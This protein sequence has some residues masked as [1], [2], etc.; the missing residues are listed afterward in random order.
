MKTTLQIIFIVSFFFL[1]QNSRAQIITNGDFEQWVPGAM[2]LDPV[3]W[4]TNNGSA[5]HPVI[6]QG[7]P[8]SGLYAVDFL[9]DSTGPGQ[10]VGGSLNF[11]YLGNLRPIALSGFWKGQIQTFGDELAVSMYVFDNTFN[12]IG[13]GSDYIFTTMSAWTAF[14]IPVNYSA[15][16]DAY[17]TLIAISLFSTVPGNVASMD[18]VTLTYTTGTND[19]I[20]AHFPS[21]VVR[22]AACGD[23]R[24]YI[25]LLSKSSIDIQVFNEFGQV[26]FSKQLQDVSGHNELII[27]SAGF[28]SGIYYCAV[29]GEGFR[30]SAKF[31]R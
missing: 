14:N 25:D 13:V 4:F 20:D 11:S 10:Y 15:P 8:H 12:T 6:A 1:F 19:L 22:P 26:L 27:P 24:L 3:G 30:R 31:F 28:N 2:G 23:Q 7:S 5:L 29:Q 18:D 17:Q 16:G 21:A 9:T